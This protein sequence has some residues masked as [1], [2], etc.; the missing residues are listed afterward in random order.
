[1]NV[2]RG[3]NDRFSDIDCHLRRRRPFPLL[4]DVVS[5]LSLEE[6]TLAHKAAALPTALVVATVKPSSTT[7]SG[8]S[9]GRSSDQRQPSG[10]SGSGGAP[11]KSKQR[12]SKQRGGKNSGNP[13]ATGGTANSPGGLGTSTDFRSLA[14]ALQYLTFTR[15]DIAYAV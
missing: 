14:G 6:M 13:P 15:P 1:M 7:P 8:G 11:S 4:K 5:E 10:G 3:L 12:R 2:I 9:G